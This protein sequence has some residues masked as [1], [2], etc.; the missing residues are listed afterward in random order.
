M[1]GSAV[2]FTSRVQRL[3]PGHVESDH[4]R[5]QSGKFGHRPRSAKPPPQYSYCGLL[6][7]PAD[8]GSLV[9]SWVVPRS[10]TARR[11]CRFKQDSNVSSLFCPAQIGSETAD[12]ETRSMPVDDPF[13]FDF[14]RQK[15]DRRTTPR[16]LLAI[17]P[18]GRTTSP[19][20]RRAN[21]TR[22][23]WILLSMI[24]GALFIGL[25]AAMAVIVL[26]PSRGLYLVTGG[27]QQFLEFRLFGNGTTT[28]DLIVS[29]FP[30]IPVMSK[31]S[32]LLLLGDMREEIDALK[33]QKRGQ[34]WS[35]LG[36]ACRSGAS[37]TSPA[38]L[39]DAEMHRP[40]WTPPRN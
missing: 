40:S 11:G 12:W 16:P 32:Y 31:D 28:R 14:A 34:G 35:M 39:L 27:S 25:V 36:Q 22:V 8:R 13:D 24:G 5:A 19:E 2:L 4:R 3:S 33:Y 6:T 7:V 37:S 17:P 18:S 10:V 38:N 1:P 9:R 21:V 15:A 23:R 30:R 26:R 20:A 29:S